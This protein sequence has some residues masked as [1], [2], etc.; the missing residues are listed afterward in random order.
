[1]PHKVVNTITVGNEVHKPSEDS[2][3]GSTVLDLYN[4]EAHTN[5]T[6]LVFRVYSSQFY[7]E[8]ETSSHNEIDKTLDLGFST[9]GHIHQTRSFTKHAQIR[10]ALQRKP[11]TTLVLHVIFSNMLCSVPPRRMYAIPMYH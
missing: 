10:R 11:S 9:I 5:S 3:Q 4:I 1:V 8:H 6:N 2:L 7:L